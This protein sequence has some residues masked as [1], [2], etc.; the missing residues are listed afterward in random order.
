MPRRARPWLLAAAGLAVL[1]LLWTLSVRDGPWQASERSR[2]PERDESPAR[3]AGPDHETSRPTL[4]GTARAPRAARGPVTLRVIDRTGMPLAHVPIRERP[5][6]AAP[7]P[8]ETEDNRA[9]AYRTDA[10]GTVALPDLPYDGTV[11]LWVAPIRTP[12][13]DHSEDERTDASTRFLRARLKKDGARV[14]FEPVEEAA[15]VAERRTE[16]RRIETWSVRVGSHMAES[17]PPIGAEERFEVVVRGPDATIVV[18][19]GLP[20]SV[21][22]R[23]AESGRLRSDVRSHVWPRWGVGLEGS[24]DPTAA[25]APLEKITLLVRVVAP[26][27]WVAA[28]AD[29]W[30]VR[31]H[32]LA[33]RLLAHQ[34]L[35]PV[36]DLVLDVPQACQPYRVEDCRIE[37]QVA[38][39]P[40]RSPSL[41]IDAQGR[42]RVGGVPHLAGETVHA[43]GRI[44]DRCP[45]QGCGITTR[46][47]RNPVVVTLQTG[48]P[49]G[50]DS[51]GW[52][53]WWMRNLRE[54]HRELPRPPSPTATDAPARSDFDFSVRL[55]AEDGSAAAGAYMQMGHGAR[56]ADAAG[57]VRFSGIHAG[58]HRVIVI[59]AG[60]VHAHVVDVPASGRSEQTLV[61]PTGGTLEVEVVDEVGRGLPFPT[62]RIDR[63]DALPHLDCVDGTQRVDPFGDAEGKRVYRHVGAGPIKVWA[64]FG[65]RVSSAEVVMTDGGHERIR[66]V[67]LGVPA[68]LEG[69]PDAEAPR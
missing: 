15:D 32:P 22:V 44:S 40:V 33:R 5:T 36:V 42:L 58:E 12:A 19:R 8:V 2:S 6:T 63:K 51:S 67:L 66:I 18:D 10:T 24:L 21:E 17:H 20:V 4:D 9:V 65:S 7:V 43:G 64:L 54:F 41:S 28:E 34:P 14:T 29:A 49:D 38:G 50:D 62:I 27:G 16:R 57:R 31:I 3:D 30:E 56:I 25:V 37:V 13:E 53:L 52:E 23:E 68:A 39:E 26:E 55:V 45:V 69:S 11:M 48:T 61:L 35:R 1:L 46:D 59:G 60:P 47:P